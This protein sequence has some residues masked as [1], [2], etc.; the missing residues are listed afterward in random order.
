MNRHQERGLEENAKKKKL[1]HE[2]A[3]RYRQGKPPPTS[4]HHLS[5]LLCRSPLSLENSVVF[6]ISK[7]VG[8]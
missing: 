2:P 4:S 7:S 8:H 1:D 6:T 5:N 3:A